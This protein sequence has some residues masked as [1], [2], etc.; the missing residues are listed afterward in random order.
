MYVYAIISSFQGVIDGVVFASTNRD[1]AG[2]EL[3]RLVR[4][5]V[6]LMYGEGARGWSLDD[7]W[8][9]Y[10]IAIESC[11]KVTDYVLDEF[12]VKE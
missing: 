8:L 5:Q 11:A 10:G 9:E 3:D 6:V 7:V 12:E 2:A 4:E 1:D